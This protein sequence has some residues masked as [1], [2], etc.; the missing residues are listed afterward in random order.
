MTAYRLKSFSEN[1][2]ITTLSKRDFLVSFGSPF[3]ST[4]IQMAVLLLI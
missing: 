3:F 2:E 1:G 4:I